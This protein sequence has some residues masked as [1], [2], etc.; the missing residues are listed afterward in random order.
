MEFD[1]TS[2]LINAWTMLNP[3]TNK[4]LLSIALLL[5]G[6]LIA[7][8]LEKAIVSF[9]Q[10]IW[11]DKLA[12]WLGWET[13]ALKGGVKQ[14]ISELIGSLAYWLIALLVVI[15]VAEIAGLPVAVVLPTL[16]AYMGVV[17][18]AALILALGVF[19]AGLLSGF[20]S[21]VMANLGLEGARTVS[22]VIYYIII[23]FSFLAALSQLGFNP[24]WTPHIGIILGAPALAVAIAFG[25]GCKDMAADF[26]HNLFRKGGEK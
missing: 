26:I 18:L 2:A 3:L 17:F 9:L 24:D 11:L 7:R 14:K 16:F 6:W 8:I 5:A 4:L 13:F 21:L 1:P 25:L 20:I 15:G 22:R 10:L 23:V 19:L 12:N